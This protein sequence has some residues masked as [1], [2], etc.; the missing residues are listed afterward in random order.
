MEII[1]GIVIIITWNK[2]CCNEITIFLFIN[3]VVT[4]KKF[5]KTY[6]AKRK[7]LKFILFWKYINFKS[8]YMY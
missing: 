7:S 5:C 4:Y 3:F 6:D 1:L 8:C 2:R